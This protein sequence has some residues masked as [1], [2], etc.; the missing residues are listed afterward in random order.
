MSVA[1]SPR[2]MI[3]GMTFPQPSDG[4][5]WVQAPAGPA[6]RATALDHIADHIFTT[7]R[8]RLGT[9]AGPGGGDGWLGVAAAMGVDAARLAR[10]NQVHGAAAIVAE[11][12]S[13]TARPRADILVTRDAAIAVAVQAADCVPLVA[14]DRRTGA[15]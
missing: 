1:S 2:P 4:F 5:E 12:T 7:R 11:S 14:A 6:L 15:V 10:L 3:V 8:W 13:T 9:P